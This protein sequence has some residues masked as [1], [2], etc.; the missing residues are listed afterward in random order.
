MR[1]LRWHVKGVPRDVRDVARESA[2]ISGVSVGA[3]LNSLIIKAADV[4]PRDVHTQFQGGATPAT[5]HPRRTLRPNEDHIAKIVGQIDELK[6]WIDGLSH[7]DSARH[8]SAAA[9][10][11]HSKRL[12]ETVARGARAVRYPTEMRAPFRNQRWAGS[13]V[14]WTKG[15]RPLPGPTHIAGAG[16]Y[17]DE[18][19]NSPKN[20]VPAG[21][22]SSLTQEVRA[23]GER[24][25]A[26]HVLLRDRPGLVDIERSL[27]YLR[28]RIDA[29][30]PVADIANLA[31]TVKIL[32]QKAIASQATVPEG[33]RRL[34]DAVSALRGLA[35]QMASPTK[36]AELSRD[37]HGLAERIDNIAQPVH[38]NMMTLNK[39][40]AEMTAAFEKSR[41]ESLTIPADFET[42]VQKLADRL[43]AVEVRSADQGAL[44]KL[45]ALIVGLVEKLDAS[46]AR[47]SRL[48]GVERG[49]SELLEQINALRAQNEKKLQAI[50]QELVESTIPAAND[51]AE[52]MR[53]VVALTNRQSAFDQRT[54]ERFEAVCGTIEQVVNRLD[55]ID[56]ELRV[57]Q[58]N[59]AWPTPT[60]AAQ[61]VRPQ[62]AVPELSREPRALSEKIDQIARVAPAEALMTPEKGLAHSAGTLETKRVETAG[63]SYDF[64]A[65]I[66]KLAEELKSIRIGHLDQ[67]AIKDLQ[68]RQVKPAAPTKQHADP[69]M[70]PDF[71]TLPADSWPGLDS[72]LTTNAFDRCV[73]SDAG[74][75]VTDVLLPLFDR[76]NFVAAG[77]P[78]V[79][80][81]EKECAKQR[82]AFIHQLQPRIKP[83]IVGIGFISLLLGAL[84]DIAPV[85]TPVLSKLA[86]AGPG[87]DSPPPGKGTP[88]ISQPEPL[89]SRLSSPAASPANPPAPSKVIESSATVLSDVKVDAPAR[90][91][92]GLLPAASLAPQ[93]RRSSSRGKRA[94]TRRPLKCLQR[95]SR[96]PAKRLGNKAD[97]IRGHSLAQP[98][99]RDFQTI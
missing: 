62:F 40:L 46:E 19:A 83:L 16:K 76:P 9:E 69:G 53:R 80:A 88:S 35:G 86:A 8:A 81:N 67:E 6:R 50:Q 56:E 39:R 90:A 51:P 26:N 28:Q 60:L 98:C 38:C 58:G 78:V 36:I 43:E 95:A 72:S 18:I 15:S 99:S 41:A 4:R 13:L 74:V 5:R 42:V 17:L 44:K 14:K 92:S 30:A 66:K 2:R 23:L 20:T 47:L 29:I 77:H 45:E 57:R 25:E 79:K 10:V 73:A 84:W 59:A 48:D 91:E 12:E 21:A 71:S 22:L 85:A 54:H 75:A 11:M 68:G 31:E 37:I 33:L 96:V 65:V 24:I 27:A 7:D 63:I 1:A 52:T 55:A 93:V 3:W 87:S 70:P 89:T 64:E 61:P 82:T 94:I 97:R 49:V 34:E 32:S